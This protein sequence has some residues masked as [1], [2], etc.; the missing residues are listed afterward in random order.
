[1]YREQPLFQLP[2]QVLASLLDLDENMTQWR[3]RHALMAHRMLGQKIGTGG[4]SGHSY[5]KSA[6]EK[7]KIF[8]DFFNLSTF[9]IPRSKVPK[10]P[11][12]LERKMNYSL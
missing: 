9:L 3:Y 7:H 12:D 2:F 5:L 8:Q 10:L 1:L 4:S 6:T 11:Q